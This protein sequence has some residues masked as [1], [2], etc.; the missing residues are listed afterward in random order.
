MA[1]RASASPGCA[2]TCARSRLTSLSLAT[3][4]CSCRDRY[5]RSCACH[6]QQ[7]LDAAMSHTGAGARAVS[8][9]RCSR[10]LA[11]TSSVARH[12]TQ[13]HIK[14]HP[15]RI[16]AVKVS[17]RRPPEDH[18]RA[19]SGE[20]RRGRIRASEE[21]RADQPPGSRLRRPRGNR[22]TQL[23]NR[24]CVVPATMQLQSS[25]TANHT[26]GAKSYAARTSQP[27]PAHQSSWYS[28]AA[29]VPPARW[30]VRSPAATHSRIASTTAKRPCPVRIGT[31]DVHIAVLHR[32]L[33][34]TVHGLGSSR[35]L[36]KSPE[37]P[38]K[39]PQP[40]GRRHPSPE[41]PRGSS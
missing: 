19:A 21:G 18:A 7:M 9:E 26:C 14:P 22:Q 40:M 5:T 15:E 3:Y 34:R 8:A 10:F 29:S 39:S 20:G 25:C 35:F 1:F 41:M 32:W 31:V 38:V 12:A 27:R 16:G 13:V 30:S 33:R 23:E 17:R 2:R 28:S 37:K 11:S 36:E 6:A 4:C 24:A